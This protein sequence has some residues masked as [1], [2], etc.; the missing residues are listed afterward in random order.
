M[1]KW[2]FFFTQNYATFREKRPEWIIFICCTT[3]LTLA[4]IFSG[5]TTSAESYL[6][7]TWCIL[8]CV[9]LF[10]PQSLSHDETCLT[11]W[12]TLHQCRMQCVLAKSTIFWLTTLP[13]VAIPICICPILYPIS[14]LTLLAVLAAQ[15]IASAIFSLQLCFLSN[16]IYDTHIPAAVWPPLLLPSMLGI[17]WLGVEITTLACTNTFLFSPF[18]LL[19][20]AWIF[21]LAIIVWLL[22]A[23]TK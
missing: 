5:I 6:R 13:A 18:A 12:A 10:A 7:A 19:L 20:T 3:F 8:T 4:F 11:T 15:L 22:H 17:L 1:Q 14:I 2:L 16:I 23:I 21:I 9:T